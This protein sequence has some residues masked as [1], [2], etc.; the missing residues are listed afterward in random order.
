LGSRPFRDLAT[1][2]ADD[3][4]EHLKGSQ[5]VS[6][7]RVH[8]RIKVARGS[9][10]KGSFVLRSGRGR[11]ARAGDITLAESVRPFPGSGRR[12]HLRSD[13]RPL[14]LRDFVFVFQR[15]V[16]LWGFWRSRRIFDDNGFSR[17]PARGPG[18]RVWHSLLDCVVGCPDG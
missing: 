18:H 6:K 13:W 2:D 17:G 8:G 11:H 16:D 3:L 1:A 12:R 9:R 15:A 14:D 5:P 7:A 4:A 10:L